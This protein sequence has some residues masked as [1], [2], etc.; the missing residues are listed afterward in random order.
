MPESKHFP[1]VRQLQGGVLVPF[2]VQQ[3]TRTDEDGEQTTFYR[4]GQVKLEQRNLPALSQ[5]QHTAWR[6]LQRAL[7]DHI[8]PRYDQGSQSTIQAYA[9][10]AERQGRSDIVAECEKIMDW[11]DACLMYYYAKKDAIYAATTEGELVGIAWD[12]GADVPFPDDVLSLKAIR[13][14]FG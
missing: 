4:F 9:Q 6:E 11:I 14:M 1:Q 7:H 8:Y 2:N 10:R 5:V 13:G 3:Q 12:F